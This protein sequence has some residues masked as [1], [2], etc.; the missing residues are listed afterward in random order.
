MSLSLG[1]RASVNL[2]KLID[3]SLAHKDLFCVN[4]I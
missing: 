2:S 1:G 4:R 3:E